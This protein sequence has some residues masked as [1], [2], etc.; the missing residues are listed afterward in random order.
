MNKAVFFAAAA[1]T[2][3]AGQALAQSSVD[4]YGRLNLSAERQNANGLKSTQLAN[5]SSRL[6]FRG[7]ET[8]GGGLK[9]G[10]VLEHGLDPSNGTAAS[11]FWGRQ[12]EVNLSG[13][14]G[15][16]RLGNF[17]SEAYFAT[18]DYISMHNHDTGPSGDALYAYAGRNTNKIAYRTPELTKGLTLEGAYSLKETAAT[19]SYELAANYSMGKLA[20][21]A[22]YEKAGNANQYAVRAFYELGAFLLGGYV[23]RDE[24]VYASGDRTTYRLAGA[25]MM[26]KS[27]FHL[28]YGRAGDYSNVANSSANQ[29]TLAYNYNLSKRTKAYT[30]YTKV[31]ASAGTSYAADFSSVALG[32]RHNF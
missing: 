19:K 28:N 18:A 10:F 11:A 5:N 21:G 9:A 8:L 17:T 22:G 3:V 2:L 6:G 13:A 25:Y 1:A 12:S 20:L 29:Y 15:T 26:G 32:L 16:V 30:Y 14:F 4:I 24:N 31:N 27:E 7:T 23:Q